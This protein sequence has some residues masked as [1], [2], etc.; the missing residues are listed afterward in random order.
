MKR[1]L[2][3]ALAVTLCICIHIEAK[4]S[5]YPDV[6]LE[7]DYAEAINLLSERGVVGG[8]HDGTFRPDEAVTR[9]QAAVFLANALELNLYHLE[10]NPFV[11]LPDDHPFAPHATALYTNGIMVGHHSRTTLRPAEQLTNAQLASLLVRSFRL[12]EE[13]NALENVRNATHLDNIRTLSDH[14]FEISIPSNQVTR[15]EL[16]GAIVYFMDDERE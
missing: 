3:F 15:A 6:P 14:S 7:H 1:L 13:E 2:G 11:D 16:A 8:Y 4:A 5:Y 9:G 10:I 12:D